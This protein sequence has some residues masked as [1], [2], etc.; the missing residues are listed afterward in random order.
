MTKKALSLLMAALMIMTFV[1]FAFATGYSG[2][3]SGDA[4][5]TI[6]KEDT[7]ASGT[8]FN[9]P[10]IVDQEAEITGGIF[11]DTV[12]VKEGSGIPIIKWTEGGTI[13]GGTFNGTV[14]NG[15]TIKATDS[16]TPKFI[17]TVTNKGTIDGGKFSQQVINQSGATISDGDF[18]AAVNNAGTIN[19]GTFASADIT[20]TGLIYGGT[21]ERLNSNTGTMYGGTYKSDFTNSGKIYGGTFEKSMNNTGTISGGTY[22]G[23]VT[24]AGSGKITSGTFNAKVDNSGSITGGVYHGYIA[25]TGAV[26]TDKIT[27]IVYAKGNN[28]GTYYCYG[29]PTLKGTIT[30]GR[31]DTFVLPE[32]R[33][34]YIDDSGVL[35]LSGD[36]TI[37]GTIYCHGKIT[38]TGATLAAGST[39]KVY[40]YVDGSI[41]GSA[42]DSI[43]KVQ[44][45]IESKDS[46]IICTDAAYA[47]DTVSFS[48]NWT[49]LNECY[50]APTVT[51]KDNKGSTVLTQ[52][53]ASYSAATNIQFI[54]PNG[55][56][57]ISMSYTESHTG[58][59]ESTTNATCTL[60]GSYK[61]YC[62]TCGKVLEERKIEKLGHDWSA[63]TY[64]TDANTLKTRKCSRC[65]LTESTY[66][67]I[68]KY[69]AQTQKYAFKSTITFH[70][71]VKAP[72]GSKLYWVING[73]EYEDNGSKSY[74]VVEATNNYT[75]QA[76]VKGL[77]SALTGKG[78]SEVETVNVKHGFFDK[79]SSFFKLLFNK[80]ALTYDQK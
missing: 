60:D 2:T 14:V 12:S 30:M 65:S 67:E 22:K 59:T 54:M 3:V 18:S 48:I 33:T 1:P 52:Q 39:G 13:S 76:K 11:N 5:I 4:A 35:N 45:A 56:A 44:Y 69:V 43:T 9:C 37:N 40:V 36:C 6:K 19:G 63:W 7:I 55:K 50:S 66:V 21:F 71:N 78:D 47:G 29:S 62:K 42:L 38:T 49:A 64:S 31:N 26:D 34:L 72:E 41:S 10:V 16:S 15:G 57:T 77:S 24:N 70:A 17:K 68:V 23:T 53:I 79:L 74:T 61:K 20:N 46:L 28:G 75:V 73:K 51:V 27:A 25:N 32:K 8:I 58:I 80:T